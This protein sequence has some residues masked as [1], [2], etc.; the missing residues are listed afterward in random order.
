MIAKKQ[1]IL[2]RVLRG[3]RRVLKQKEMRERADRR[4][5]ACDADDKARRPDNERDTHTRIWIHAPL[6]LLCARPGI[7]IK[8]VR[9][10]TMSAG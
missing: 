10:L 6:V 2:K 7:T 4:C 1:L 9:R 3:R 5:G 8:R